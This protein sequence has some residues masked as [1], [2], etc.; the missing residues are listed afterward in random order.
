MLV[1]AAFCPHPP[2]LV[3]EIASGAA[4][5]T[6]SLRSKCDAA[7]TEMLSVRPDVVV[8]LGAGPAAARFGDGDGGY[9]RDFGVDLVV[10]LGGPDRSSRADRDGMPLSLTL[11]AWL[12]ARSGHAGP[13][14]GFSV[15]DT[16]TDDELARY[17]AE[18]DGDGGRTA[19]LVMGDGSARRTPE[20][21]GYVDPRATGFDE[22]VGSAL[23]AGD[24]AALRGLDPALGTALLAAGTPAWR[25]AGWIGGARSYSARLDYRDDP[26]GVGY[27]VATW[28]D[29]TERGDGGERDGVAR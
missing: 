21:P 14:I 22:Q 9:L 16:A 1:A 23:A 3:P 7:V 15:P 4:P 6:D 10:A 8:V 17:A 29:G 28:R 27:F 24:P 20:S 25:L 2:L 5:E 18:L 13:R 19:L 11:G 12:L 26:Y